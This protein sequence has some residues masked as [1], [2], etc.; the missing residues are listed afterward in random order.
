MER[1]MECCAPTVDWMIDVSTRPGCWQ[2]DLALSRRLL[3]RASLLGLC[4]RAMDD[5]ETAA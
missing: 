2:M 3:H 5:S 4:G 1:V